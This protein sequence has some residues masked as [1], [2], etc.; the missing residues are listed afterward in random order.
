MADARCDT[1]ACSTSVRPRNDVTIDPTPMAR[2][3]MI[4]SAEPFWCLL[5]FMVSI[6]FRFHAAPAWVRILGPEIPGCAPVGSADRPR[7]HA[8]H[9]PFDVA[10]RMDEV[11]VESEDGGR[12]LGD[13]V[14][15]AVAVEVAAHAHLEVAGPGEVREVE[16]V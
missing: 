6:P 10:V 5:R 16:R 3:S 9:H 8:L 2:I 1:R 14:L 13:V 4:A 12:P 11:D 15:V 7:A